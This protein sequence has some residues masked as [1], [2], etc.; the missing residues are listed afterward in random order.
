MDWKL[1]AWLKRG[2]R[3]KSVLELLANS[4]SPISAN[5]V[6]KPLKIAISQASATLKELRQKG[7]I[8]CLNPQDSIGKLYKINLK[9]R[10]ILK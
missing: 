1:V 6:K 9:G 3:R 10:N 7:L 2:S 8:D 4:R 5:E